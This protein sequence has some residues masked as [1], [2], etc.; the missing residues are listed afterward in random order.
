MVSRDKRVRKLVSEVITVVEYHCIIRELLIIEMP[1]LTLHV[2]K[3]LLP[4]T[5][6]CF[7]LFPTCLFLMFYLY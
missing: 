4:F 6:S 2:W 1:A 3:C 5:C 7:M